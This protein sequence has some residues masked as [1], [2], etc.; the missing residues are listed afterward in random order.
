VIRAERQAEGRIW[1]AAL[2]A[3]VACVATVASAQGAAGSSAAP[4]PAASSW[5]DW[6]SRAGWWPWGGDGKPPAPTGVQSPHYGDSLFHFFQGRY[7]TAVTGLMVSQHFARVAPHDDEAE[8]LRGGLFLSYGLHREAGDVF[9]RLIERGAEPPVRDRAWFYLAKIRYQRGLLAEAEDAL[10][11]I[12]QRLP[13]ELEEDRVLLQANVQMARGRHAE[14]I[15]TLDALAKSP[16][17]N[18]YVRYNLGIALI[19]GGDPAAGT[20][21]LDAVGKLPATSEEYRN[22]R[23]KANLALGFAALRDGRG[24]A[25]RG[26]LE[27]VRLSGMQSNKALLGFGWAAAAQGNMKAA[28]VPW[29]ELVG[30]EEADAAV[31]EARL[32]VPYALAE[33]GADAQALAL[34]QTAIGAFDR[35]GANLDRSVAAIREGRLLD[36]LVARNPGEEMGWFWSIAD[37]PDAHDVPHGGH[38]APL[39]ATHE[40]QEAFKNYRDLLFLGH[41]LRQWQ[42]TLGVLRDMLDNRRAAYAERLPQVR[43]RELALGAADRGRSQAALAAELERVERDVDVA[44]LATARERELQARLGRVREALGGSAGEPGLDAARERYRRASGALLWQQNEQFSGRLWSA[45]KNL[46]ELQRQVALAKER[47]AALGRAQRDEPAR[48]DDFARRLEALAARVDAMA[49]RIDALAQ[50]QR[51]AVQELAV[52][53]LLR[54]KERLAAYGTQARFAVAQIYDRAASTKEGSRATAR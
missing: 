40:F 2:A 11:H 14:A 31:L 10:G 45:R 12:E 33:L 16:G 21:L 52:A 34:Y 44:A 28:L 25:A 4:T 15:R 20:A 54:Q 30:R 29:N 46:Q 22:L 23:D 3:V 35:E 53:E 42:D 13:G 9:A 18:S 32:A 49:P 5:S 6:S 8:V 37:L 36:G 24:D 41:N 17:A 38:L 39:L 50:Q 43:A 47:D 7:F 26:H 19:R 48:L 1:R 27:R 51:V